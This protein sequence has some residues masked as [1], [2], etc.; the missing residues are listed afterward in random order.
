MPTDAQFRSDIAADPQSVTARLVYADWLDARG[1]FLAAA[2]Q[3]VLA[4]PESDQWREQYAVHTPDQYRAAFIRTGDRKLLKY[5]SRWL[6]EPWDKGLSLM[7]PVTQADITTARFSGHFARLTWER[8]FVSRLSTD[9]DSWLAHGDV[10]C[11]SHPVT[12]VYL[13]TPLPPDSQS[14]W[15]RITFH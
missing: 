4:E 10:L 8:G 1:Q 11:D 9:A 13:V 6:P 5:A 2:L 3:R 12:H 15:P 14:R 7:F